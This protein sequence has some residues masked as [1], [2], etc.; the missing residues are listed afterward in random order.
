MKNLHSTCARSAL[1]L[2][3]G[4][5]MAVPAMAQSADAPERIQETAEEDAAVQQ[6]VVVTGSFI[7]GT[8]EDSALPVDVYGRAELEETGIS[9]PL[10]LIKSLPSVGSVLGELQP[11]RTK[12]ARLSGLRLYQHA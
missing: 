8:P 4:L 12:R 11:V 3:L 9:S 6:R 1:W 5:S 2:A 10:E 7:A